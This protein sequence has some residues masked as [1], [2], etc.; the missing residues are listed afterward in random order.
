LAFAA[1]LFSS[2]AI[3]TRPMFILAPFVLGLGLLI[4][5]GDHP[6][7]LP[8]RKNSGAALALCLPVILTVGLWVN[9]VHALYKVWGMDAMGG[10]HLVNNT[11]TFFEYVPDEYAEV[12][13][14]Y[15]QYR[16]ARL[17][18][19]GTEVNTIWDAIPSLNKALG[20]NYYSLSRLLTKISLDL[21]REHPDLYLLNVAK[22]WWW[23]WLTPVYWNEAAI[24][25]PALRAALASY[26]YAARA[27]LFGANLVF[28]TVS[29]AALAYQRLRAVL[30]MDAFQWMLVGVVMSS[31]IVQAFGEHGDNP[32][33]LLPLQS[34][35]V[36][37]VLLWAARLV[38]ALNIK[39]KPVN[40]T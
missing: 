14:I 36:F 19:R 22:G 23:A 26:I 11:G 37:L 35:V 32:R 5:R 9:Y 28:L 7:K 39:R 18:D 2:A 16:A 10:F 6:G 34:V 4:R 27:L 3:M 20:T 29:V 12:R 25:N 33:F 8:W 24:A 21:I 31:S 15:L 40:A 13:E 17:A 30:Q 1:G 38:E